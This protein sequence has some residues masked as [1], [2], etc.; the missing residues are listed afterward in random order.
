MRAFDPRHVPRP[1]LAL[2]LPLTGPLDLEIGAG[3][4]LHAIRYAQAHPERTLLAVER[5]RGKYEKMAGRKQAHPELRN[6]HVL[7]ADAVSV[8]THYLTPQSIDRVFV[9]YPNPNPKAKHA[10]LRFHN[11]PF[12]ALLRE[13]LKPGGELHLA[14]NLPWYAHEAKLKLIEQWSFELVSQRELRSGFPPRTH[15]ERKYLERGEVA[16]DFVF[17][18]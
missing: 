4:G 6:L 16:Y 8:V 12:M 15:F 18:R 17:R 5:T 1:E 13:R 11:S 9:L 10:N 14:T 7:H 2:A 3:Q